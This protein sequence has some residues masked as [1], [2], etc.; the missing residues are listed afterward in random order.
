MIGTLTPSQI[1]EIAPSVFSTNYASKLSSKYSFVPT[2]QV[3]EK[4][5]NNGWNVTSVKQV[6][7]SLHAP[8]E[9]RMSNM[10]LPQVGDSLIQAIVRNSHDGTKALTVGAGLYRL[11]CSNGLT[12]PTSLTNQFTIRHKNVE[13]DDVRRITDGFA[14]MLPILQNSVNKFQER[15]MEINEARDFMTKAT[16]LRWNT[17]SVPSLDVNQLLMPN[18]DGD[19]GL[20]LWKVFNVAQETLV[21]GGTQYRTQRGRYNSV[22]ELRNFESV[23]RVNTKLWELAETYC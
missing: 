20:S 2:E 5:M 11:V 21:R 7:R 14:D 13:M 23:N 22:R 18:R 19:L 4:F 6:G 9:I 15:E 10:D 16:L 8:H 12:V 17:G 3:L 1:K